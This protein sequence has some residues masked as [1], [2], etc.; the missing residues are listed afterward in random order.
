MHVVLRNDDY[1]TQQ[2]VCRVLEEVFELDE[3]AAHTRMLQT[4]TQG[5]AVVG[6]FRPDEARA[7]IEDVRG[8]AKAAGFPLW[9]GVEPI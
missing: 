2:F 7:K 1:T 6:R 9:I 4:H 3:A 8:R 5:R